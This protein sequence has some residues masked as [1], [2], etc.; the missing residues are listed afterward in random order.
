[1]A[2]LQGA[3]VPA[4]AG[5]LLATLLQNLVNDPGFFSRINIQDPGFRLAPP[6]VEAY[7]AFGVLLRRDLAIDAHPYPRATFA[8]PVV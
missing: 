5:V 1:M 3:G 2:K 6:R 7:D 8:I 4:R